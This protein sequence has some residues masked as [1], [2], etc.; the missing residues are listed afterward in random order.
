[1]H[2]ARDDA[3]PFAELL[4][5]T[6][7]GLRPVRQQPTEPGKAHG[8]NH[9]TLRQRA[10]D[11]GVGQ[12]PQNAAGIDDEGG[13]LPGNARVGD[14]Q[15]R[16]RHSATLEFGA[17]AQQIELAE[18]LDMHQARQ[19]PVIVHALDLHTPTAGHRYIHILSR[20]ARSAAH[21]SRRTRD[22]GKQAPGRL[23]LEWRQQFG[24]R[25]DFRERHAE[26]CG[27]EADPVANVAHLTARILLE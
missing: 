6:N 26:P 4:R 3:D 14:R 15:H 25:D 2:R 5:E 7:P 11:G 13:Y 24:L 17:N 19:L 8:T 1:M 10:R 20:G 18:R 27:R 21:L 16:V 23:H 12:A 9:L 22:V